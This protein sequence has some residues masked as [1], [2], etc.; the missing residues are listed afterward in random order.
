M[1]ANVG[2]V[3]VGQEVVGGGGSTAEQRWRRSSSKSGELEPAL[4]VLVASLEI[5]KDV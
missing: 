5:E 2:V 1:I 4:L 3:G